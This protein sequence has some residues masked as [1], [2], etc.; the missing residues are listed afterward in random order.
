VE[1]LLW[2][3]KALIGYLFDLSPPTSSAAPLKDLSWRG[4]RPLMSNRMPY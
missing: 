1:K 2:V 4:C 3:Y